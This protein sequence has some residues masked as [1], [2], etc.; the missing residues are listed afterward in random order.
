MQ[1]FYY[2]SPYFV[3]LLVKGVCH[4]NSYVG[5]SLFICIEVNAGNPLVKKREDLNESW[6][7]RDQ[8]ASE[9]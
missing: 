2:F 3:S 1:L 4:L 8:I 6:V 7:G 5:I 9:C